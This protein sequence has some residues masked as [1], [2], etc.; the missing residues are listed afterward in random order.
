MKYEDIWLDGVLYRRYVNAKTKSKR[1]Y[2]RSFPDGK[3]SDSLHRVIWKNHNGPIPPGMHVHHIDGNPLNNDVSNLRCVSAEEHY[4]EHVEARSAHIKTPKHLEKLRQLRL[5]AAEWHRSPDGLRWHSDHSKNI[6][7]NRK[8][9]SR[10]CFFC[11][12]SFEA[13][14]GVAARFCGKSCY[15]RNRRKN[16]KEQEKQ[17]EPR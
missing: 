9:E 4:I 2:Y 10:I 15:D 5:L 14:I 17:T 16:K 11:G 13:Y 12:N 1:N 7:K 8:K 3:P 6:W